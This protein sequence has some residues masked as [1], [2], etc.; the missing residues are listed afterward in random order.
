[1]K[2]NIFSIAILTILALGLSV[3]AIT[4]RVDFTGSWKL[5]TAKSAGLPPGMEQTM[6]VKQTGDEIKLETVVKGGPQ[7]EQTVA[8]AYV[9]DGKEHDFKPSNA[10]EGARGKRTAKW[11][12]NGIDVAEK[13]EITG[14]ADGSTVTIEATR[15]WVLSADGKT[16]TIEIK[17]KTPQGEQ[18]N[19]RIFVK[20]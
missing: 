16:L 2:K 15:K 13:L 5:N 19:R 3:S 8:D 10:P 1:M 11:N 14:A 18:N 9:L 6:I 4:V 12:A 17:S 20:Q 7:G